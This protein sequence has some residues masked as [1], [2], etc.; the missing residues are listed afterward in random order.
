MTF[1]PPLYGA[2]DILSDNAPHAAPHKGEVEYRRLRGC[3]I[4]FPLATDDRVLGAPLGDRNI[5]PLLITLGILEFEKIHGDHVR[6][7]LDEASLV[8]NKI[9][10]L[11]GRNAIMMATLGTDV[12]VLLDVL[13][14]EDL[15]ATHTLGPES[16]GDPGLFLFLLRHRRLLARKPT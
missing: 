7:I 13:G 10:T 3:L 12:K 16:L 14:V 5:D 2:G 11:A 1:D 15:A 9:D 6:V 4:D 8:E